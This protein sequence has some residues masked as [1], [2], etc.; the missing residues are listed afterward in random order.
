MIQRFS[1][2]HKKE[3]RW[4]NDFDV[5]ITGDGDM[6]LYGESI[7]ADGYIVQTEDVEIV[8]YTGKQDKNG[9][10]IRE[11]DIMLVIMPTVEYEG[12]FYEK[13]MYTEKRI[14]CE[15][16]TRTCGGLGLLIRKVLPEGEPGLKRGSFIRINSDKD[17][18]IGHVFDTPE[19]IE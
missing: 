17:E 7:E 16:R 8:H 6:Y 12:N 11:K 13:I 5:A 9:K 14:Y 2:W 4:L 1:A 19:L 3:K 18:I 15:V 10:E